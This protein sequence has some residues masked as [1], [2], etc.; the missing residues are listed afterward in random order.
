[1]R[2]EGRRKGEEKQQLGGGLLTFPDRAETN[3]LAGVLNKMNIKNV[4]SISDKS[5]IF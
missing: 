4:V 1:M 2:K 3:F 5:W